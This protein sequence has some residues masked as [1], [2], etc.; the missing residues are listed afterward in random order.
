MTIYRMIN[1][2]ESKCIKMHKINNNKYNNSICKVF[3]VYFCINIS[4]VYL[5]LLLMDF[6]LLVVKKRSINEIVKI[7]INSCVCPEI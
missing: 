5:F 3:L 1:A 7:K 2:N 4:S 6:F